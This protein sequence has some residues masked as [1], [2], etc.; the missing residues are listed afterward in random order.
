MKRY[1]FSP[2]YSIN[3]E[4]FSKWIGL[5]ES[6]NS[7]W[8]THV[9]METFGNRYSTEVKI[10]QALFFAFKK[11]KSD[12]SKIRAVCICTLCSYA[13]ENKISENWMRRRFSYFIGMSWGAEWI[14]G[15]GMLG[16]WESWRERTCHLK[17]YVF[18]KQSEVPFTLGVVKLQS[19][20]L[21]NTNPKLKIS[22]LN[23]IVEEK[24][25]IFPT[26]SPSICFNSIFFHFRGINLMLTQCSTWQ[27]LITDL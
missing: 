13:L 2:L 16:G 25:R 11:K 10:F 1:Q 26:G 5:K 17:G 8:E 9:L 22:G 14:T 3:C 24:Y 6:S 21:K 12:I 7:L 4:S 15:K 19:D 23:N 18:H 20:K 27:T